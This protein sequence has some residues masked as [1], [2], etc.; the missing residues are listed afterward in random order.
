M[1]SCICCVCCKCCM[2]LCVLLFIGAKDPEARRPVSG[3]F[4]E[5]TP[6]RRRPNPRNSR[7]SSGD[8]VIYNGKRPLLAAKPVKLAKRAKP[9]HCLA[10]NALSPT[11]PFWPNCARRAKNGPMFQRGKPAGP[12]L[13]GLGQVA[14]LGQML[15][16]SRDPPRRPAG[17]PP[18]GDGRNDDGSNTK[19]AAPP[20]PGW[21]LVPRGCRIPQGPSPAPTI[22]PPLR[23]SGPGRG[24]IKWSAPP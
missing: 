17:D 4:G 15:G 19:Q 21:R 1:F 8:A 3:L 14:C 24:V 7:C 5:A 12:P 6:N 11:T 22:P 23:R 10:F 20:G 18:R 16:G 13:S 2:L 9:G